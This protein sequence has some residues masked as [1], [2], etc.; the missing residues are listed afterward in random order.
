MTEPIVWKGLDHTAL[1]H[2]VVYKG[3]GPAASMDVE[4]QWRRIGL[5]ITRIERDLTAALQAS[6]SEWSGSAADATRTG[7][8]PLGQWALDAAG[9]AASTAAAVT[10]QALASAVLRSQLRDN[11]P[12]QLATT[13]VLDGA[14]HRTWAPSADEVAIQQAAQ[15]ERDGAAAKAVA[16]AHVYENIGYQS[17]RTLD[18][19]TVPPTVTV[20]TASA[21]GPGGG[22]GGS[23]VTGGAAAATA[24]GPVAAALPA[25]SPAGS[26]PPV[27]SFSTGGL[28][29]GGPGA[30]PL[31]PVGPGPS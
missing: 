28:G 3:L 31:G 18:F 26:G 6:E 30:G 19:W 11:P 9:D 20:E 8:T 15:A 23:H 25:G 1:Y 24:P 14:G 4:E 17:R 22:F 27:A 16:D 7:L 13:K 21:G 29:G 5:T 2:A 12:V 10:D